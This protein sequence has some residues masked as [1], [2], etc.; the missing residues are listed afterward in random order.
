MEKLKKWRLNE[1]HSKSIIQGS[2]NPI[3]LGT[4][5]M[6]ATPIRAEEASA[7]LEAE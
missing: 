5:F 6:A 1:F 2:K 3:S 4:Y 7:R